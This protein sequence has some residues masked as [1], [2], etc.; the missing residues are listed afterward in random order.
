MS[1]P[2]LPSSVMRLHQLEERFAELEPQIAHSP[3][4]ESLSALARH[5]V[6]S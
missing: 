5:G 4:R 3:V 2:I 6:R 1:T